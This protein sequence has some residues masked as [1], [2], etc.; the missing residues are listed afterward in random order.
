M[1]GE[2]PVEALRALAHPMRY[3]IMRALAGAER[4]VGDIETVTGFGQPKLSQQLAVLRK[5]G[6]VETRKDSKL[7]YYRIS[8]DAMSTI[9]RLLENLASF[10]PARARPQRASAR[11]GPS[12]GAANFARLP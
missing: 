12:E 5:A 1:S 4:N 3:A 2:A 7:V 11:P 9:V 8:P 6:L 10:P